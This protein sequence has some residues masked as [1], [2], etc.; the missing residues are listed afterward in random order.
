LDSDWTGAREELDDLFSCRLC[1]HQL[2]RDREGSVS[3]DRD[4]GI[5]DLAVY[6]GIPEMTLRRRVDAWSRGDRT[7]YA[8]RGGRTGG[9]R[10]ARRVGRVEAERV[11]RQRIGEI[12]ASVNA[13]EYARG[14]G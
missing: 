9:D 1:G 14:N 7:P 8:I 10:G 6:T 4:L 13:D 11:R 2:S 3:A 12:D 5:A